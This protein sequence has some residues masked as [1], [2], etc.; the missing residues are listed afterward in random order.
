MKLFIDT[1]KVEEIREAASWGIIDGVTTNPSHIAAAGR[2][3]RPLIEEICSLI[4]GPI[5]VE[6]TSLTAEE[7]VAEARELAGIHPNIVVKIPLLVEGIKAVKILSAEGIRTN[8]TLNFSAVQAL[9][10]AKA[11]ATYISPFVGRLDDAGQAGMELVRQIRRIYDNYGFGTQVLA[12]ALRHPGHV[13]EAALAGADVA[14][15]RFDILRA[16]FEH[17][18]TH[19]GLAKFLEDWKKVQV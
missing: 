15:A 18:M 10:A 1:A 9:L 4:D 2:P 11:G 12:A 7:M 13:L 14:T 16:L 3:F 19:A 8:V 6:V 17:P 5:S